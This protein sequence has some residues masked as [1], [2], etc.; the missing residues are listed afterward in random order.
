MIRQPLGQRASNYYPCPYCSSGEEYAEAR[1]KVIHIDTVKFD[2]NGKLI[3]EP[4]PP[5]P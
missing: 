3:E 4:Q 5:T 2:E 1:G